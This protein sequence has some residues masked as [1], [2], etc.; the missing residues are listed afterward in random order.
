MTALGEKKGKQHTGDTEVIV[1]DCALNN[2]MNT[3]WKPKLRRKGVETPW[4]IN[5]QSYNDG[6]KWKKNASY[7][8][9][10]Q[11]GA[12]NVKNVIT[13]TEVGLK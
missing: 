13:Y 8:K 6:L 5:K 11:Y 3:M 1:L 7:T 2:S 4:M 10:A 9:R 12:F